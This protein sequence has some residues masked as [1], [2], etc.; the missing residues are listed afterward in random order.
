MDV[1]LNAAA[2]HVVSSHIGRLCDDVTAVTYARSS[3]LRLLA[4]SKYRFSYRVPTHLESPRFFPW[5][6]QA[7]EG[8][9]VLEI[10]ALGKSKSKKER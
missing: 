7:L 8:W 2:S 4:Q 9:K 3:D 5:I 1:M 10:K 6:F